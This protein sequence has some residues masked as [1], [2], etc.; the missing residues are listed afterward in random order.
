MRTSTAIDTACHNC[1]TARPRVFYEV[2]NV[3]VHSCLLLDS[4]EQAR[5]YPRGNIALALCE[6]CG[7]IQNSVFDSSLHEYSP[8]YE[9]TQAF[10]PRFNAFARELSEDYARAY[11]LRGKTVL[12]IGCGKGDFLLGLCDLADCHGIGIDPSFRADR[13]KPEAMRRIRFIPEFYAPEHG[14]LEA[15]LILCRHTL[16]HIQPTRQFVQRVHDTVAGR[17]DVAVSFEL[18][19]TERVLDECAFWD[20]Y[21]EHCSYFT[22]DSLRVLFESCGFDIVEQRSVFEGQYLVLDAVPSA[23]PRD[24]I[25]KKPDI[26]QWQDRVRH[27]ERNF[28]QQQRN[29][30][31]FFASHHANDRTIALWGSGSKAVAF[32][33]TLGIG[34]E[35]SAV[36]DVNPHRHH[37]FM[38]GTGH[39]ILPPTS[40]MQSRPD[41]VVAMNPIYLAEIRA[42]LLAM[43]LRPEL[44]AV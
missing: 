16:E 37:K 35:V 10:S 31:E 23:T 41:V 30:R 38:P 4:A 7:F 19:D 26:A 14:D 3:P 42:D 36:V 21:Y 44:T 20:I 28:E 39:E 24:E 34:T 8:R 29:W 1:G 9:E 17:N 33:T 13:V 40:L 27:F 6:T 32:M 5:G 25:Q 12:E 18:P 11:D 22:G 15:D 43:G 2:E